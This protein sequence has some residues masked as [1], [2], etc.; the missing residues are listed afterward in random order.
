MNQ[1]FEE[2]KSAIRS[3][4]ELKQL[5]WGQCQFTLVPAKGTDLF[6]E[7]LFLSAPQDS[8]VSNRKSVSL[9]TGSLVRQ[10]A[11]KRCP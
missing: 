6:M 9:L 10:A 7:L 5:F 8:I 4:R 2:L 1:H 3:Q 11:E